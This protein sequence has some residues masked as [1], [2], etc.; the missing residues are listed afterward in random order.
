[1][2]RLTPA[3]F[4]Q[5]LH[6]IFQEDEIILIVAG[7][8]LGALAGGLQWGV[9]V[10]FDKRQE[11]KRLEAAEEVEDALHLQMSQGSSTSSF[12]NI[13]PTAVALPILNHDSSYRGVDGSRIQPVG[14]LSSPLTRRVVTEYKKRLVPG[15]KLYYDNL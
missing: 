3:E 7:G 15:D 8:V 13:A 1:M 2:R 9:N 12:T 4:E 6:P 10:Y 11:R 14:W 5:V